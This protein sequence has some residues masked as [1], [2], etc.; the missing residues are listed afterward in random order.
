MIRRCAPGGGGAQ[1]LRGRRA[2][3]S[4][5]LARFV[6]VHLHFAPHEAAS[7][8]M[9]GFGTLNYTRNQRPVL[10]P[11]GR[12]VIRTV[13]HH[14][15]RRSLPISHDG[16]RRCGDG[17]RSTKTQD[18]SSVYDVDATGHDSRLHEIWPVWAVVR[19]ATTYPAFT[20]EAAYASAR[21]HLGRRGSRAERQAPWNPWRDPQLPASRIPLVSPK[22]QQHRH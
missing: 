14:G 4:K 19:R 18:I 17:R 2:H 16:R 9:I 3:A 22:R 6:I 20:L 7:G 13:S 1:G 8:G 21:R 5:P 12:R 10:G 11:G 15:T